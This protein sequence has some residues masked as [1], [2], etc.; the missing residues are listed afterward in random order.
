MENTLRKISGN[1]KF[2]NNGVLN[3]R[4]KKAAKAAGLDV[5]NL[6][7]EFI[8]KFSDELSKGVR[9]DIASAKASAGRFGFSLARSQAIMTKKDLQDYSK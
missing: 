4:G 6:D 7:K 3:A 5:E 1:P 9:L 2:S 8:K